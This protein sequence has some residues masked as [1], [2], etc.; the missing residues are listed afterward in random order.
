[1]KNKVKFSVRGKIPSVKNT[2]RCANGR[3]YHSDNSIA[4]YKKLFSLLTPLA[5]KDKIKGEFRVVLKI[6]RDS[7]RSDPTNKIDTIMDAMEFSGVIENDR[8]AVMGAWDAT[9]IDPKD[10]RV[11]VEV[12]EL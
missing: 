11:E 4:N 6:V 5:C 8:K 3:F 2:L 7:K 10:P 1:M 9:E 12:E